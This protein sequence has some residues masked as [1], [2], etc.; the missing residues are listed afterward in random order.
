M[1]AT[2]FFENKK[3]PV[4]GVENIEKYGS[5]FAENRDIIDASGYKR[6]VEDAEEIV[7]TKERE[8]RENN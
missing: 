3:Q 6:Y 5:D 4:A 2:G 7:F 8:E 1:S